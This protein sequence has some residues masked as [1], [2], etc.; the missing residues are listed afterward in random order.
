MRSK[1][2]SDPSERDEAVERY[3]DLVGLLR[4]AKN[5]SLDYPQ[6][7]N[8]IKKLFDLQEKLQNMTAPKKPITDSNY[9]QERKTAKEIRGELGKDFDLIGLVEKI[10]DTKISD[11]TFLL[12][13][14]LSYLK[15]LGAL[16]KDKMEN[17]KELLANYFATNVA[18]AL[19]PHTTPDM[20]ELLVTTFT[21]PHEENV[22]PNICFEEASLFLPEMLGG[23]FL[24]HQFPKGENWTNLEMV[25]D[26]LKKSFAHRLNESVW[27]DEDTRIEARNKLEKMGV[28]IG[29]PDWYADDAHMEKFSQMVKKSY[30]RAL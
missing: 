17:D 13:S 28:H 9:K 30:F 27:M 3:S 29:Y 18:M 21:E 14:D 2:E 25:V 1:R 6:L 5:Y 24:A 26:L 22:L 15:N 10:Y 7:K 23:L 20:V 11:E 4:K 19:A 8:D 16:L 12:V